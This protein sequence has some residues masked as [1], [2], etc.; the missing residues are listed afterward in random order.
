MSENER[1]WPFT[2]IRRNDRDLKR[3]TGRRLDDPP[4]G[5]ALGPNQSQP[6]PPD[7][8]RRLFFQAI[9]ARPKIIPAK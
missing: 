4:S 7:G 9:Q 2:D 5:L 3:P 8:M 6:G 1:D